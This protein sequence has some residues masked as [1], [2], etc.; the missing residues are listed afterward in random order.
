MYDVQIHNA[1]PHLQV[2]ETLL[3]DVVRQTLQQERIAAAEISLA[4]L[5]DAAIHE[6]NRDYLHHDFPTDVLSFL[7]TADECRA[8]SGDS[9]QPAA[10]KDDASKRIE[11]EVILSA[12]TACR[13]AAEF[14]WSPHDE[15]VL[16]LVHGLLH[17]A[18][19]DDR[20]SDERCRMRS[21]ERAVLSRWNLTPRYD[22]RRAGSQEESLPRKDRF[23]SL[24]D[25]S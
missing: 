21:R 7:L 25:T 19:Y 13:R 23:P 17:L 4:I 22:D 14:G 9:P 8:E 24:G 1:Q 15:I 6:L 11:G 10:G 20:T 2:D 12:E 5:D 16:Y 18:G 3:R